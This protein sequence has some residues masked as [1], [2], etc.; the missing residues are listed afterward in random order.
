MPFV[1]PIFISHQGCPQHCLFCNQHTIAGERKGES[2]HVVHNEQMAQVAVTI[3]EWLA[4][5]RRENREGGREHGY[6][7]VQV[8]FFGGSFTCLSLRYQD[9]L[10]AAVQ[11]FLQSGDVDCIRLSTRPDCVE[12]A[13]CAHLLA[14]GVRIVELGI[15]SLDARV[16]E[17]SHRGH[18]AYDCRRA[19]VCLQ[20][21]GMELGVQLMP[22][23]PFENTASFLRTIR[24]VVAMAPSFVR[25]YPVLVMEQTE[26]AAAYRRGEYRPLSMNLALARSCRAKEMLAAAGIKVVRIG[27]QATTALEHGLVAGPWHPAFGELV[28]A[29]I[30][31][32]RIRSLLASC[33][34]GKRLSLQI[35]PADLSAVLGQKRCNW[36]RLEQLGLVSRLKLE[37]DITL[38]RG[39]LKYAVH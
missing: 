5:P 25:L 26:L 21:A 35:A 33:P 18:D 7:S 9:A 34:P 11:P 22:G 20:A 28:T 14:R 37:T 8:A 4:R 30:W 24:E 27:L 1:I 38:P 31:F 17:A 2:D 10:L 36:Q 12:S 3:S 29:R 16:L 39:T 13:T 19:V 15:Q 6:R 23:L 32:K